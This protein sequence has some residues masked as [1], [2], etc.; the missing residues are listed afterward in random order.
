MPLIA[1]FTTKKP[2]TIEELYDLIKDHTF[3][4]GK[5]TLAQQASY[6]VIAFPAI[7]EFNQ[8]TIVPSGI[9]SSNYYQKWAVI[10]NSHKAGIGNAIKNQFLDD[11]SFGVTGMF[12]FF[13]KNANKG[14][15]DVE[16][17]AQE[18]QALDL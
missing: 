13:G 18:M 14:Y 2:Y 11:V 6:H 16:K 9:Q 1:H 17:I 12:S 5:P 4:A 8:V 10:K 15:E 7:D 3:S